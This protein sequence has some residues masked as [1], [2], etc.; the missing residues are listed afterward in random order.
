MIHLSVNAVQEILKTDSFD[1]HLRLGAI[2][3]S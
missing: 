1:R 2:A 3:L